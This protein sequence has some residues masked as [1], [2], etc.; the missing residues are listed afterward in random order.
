MTLATARLL[1]G[2]TIVA[3]D[4]R[5]FSAE[6]AGEPGVMAH[7]PILTLDNGARI[8][9]LTEETECGSYGVKPLYH[10]KP[11]RTRRTPETRER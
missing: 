2:R 3:V 11:K 5:P 10:P 9:F 1:V 4:L 7:D 6:I 8:T